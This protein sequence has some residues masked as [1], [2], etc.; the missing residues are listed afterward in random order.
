MKASNQLHNLAALPPWK[1]Q[2]VPTEQ[3]LG[4]HYSGSGLFKKRENILPLPE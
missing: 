4:G 2:P 1:E 3:K